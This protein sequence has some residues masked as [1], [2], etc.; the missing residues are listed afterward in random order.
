MTFRLDE[1]LLLHI[2]TC[3]AVSASPHIQTASFQIKADIDGGM[4]GSQDKEEVAYLKAKD[5]AGE[6]S[7]QVMAAFQQ[8]QINADQVPSVQTAIVS[9]EAIL[10]AKERPSYLDVEVRLISLQN[11]AKEF[12]DTFHHKSPKSGLE[13]DS[14]S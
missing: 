8:M 4:E 14:W 9:L 7:Y 1:Q 6:G 10:A 12:F 2:S 3:E 11:V 5:A 13:I